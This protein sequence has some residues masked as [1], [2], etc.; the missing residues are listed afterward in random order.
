MRLLATARLYVRQKLTACQGIDV[1]DQYV[2][3]ACMDAS[4]SIVSFRKGAIASY[5]GRMTGELRQG[6]ELRLEITNG[7]G[8]FSFPVRLQGLSPMGRQRYLFSL[9]VLDY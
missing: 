8:V 1:G 2:E 3:V 9:L 6:D 4:S 5:A 7:A